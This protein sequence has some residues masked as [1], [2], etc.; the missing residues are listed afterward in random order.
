MNNGYTLAVILIAAAMTALTRILPHLAFSRRAELPQ[1]VS[2]L[3]ES[4]PAA[5]MVILVAYCLRSI[6]FA[7]YP[8]GIPE[9]ISVL[10]VVFLQFT[11][12]KTFLSIVAGTAVYMIIIRTAFPLL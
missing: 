7:A 10:V 5:I 6:D 9:A 8:S 3:G 1:T 2:Y 4:L 12:K 11:L